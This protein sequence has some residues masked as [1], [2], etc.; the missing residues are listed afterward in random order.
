M[1]TTNK[2]FEVSYSIDGHILV[3]EDYWVLDA[4]LHFYL[5]NIN[6]RR[7][8]TL[9]YSVLKNIKFLCATIVLFSEIHQNVFNISE[10]HW[11]ISPISEIDIILKLGHI[12]TQ[13]YIS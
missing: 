4:E 5:D 1:L 9:P 13:V 7:I 12:W 3:T 6:V 11:K 8:G 10:C 2:I